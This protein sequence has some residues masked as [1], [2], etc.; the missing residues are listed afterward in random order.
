M[1]P[2][3]Q[4]DRRL[5]RPADLDPSAIALVTGA[6]SGLGEAFAW[7]LAALGWSL[8]L[9]ARRQDRLEALAK[10][11]RSAHG[12]SVTV[13]SL[14]LAQPDAVGH[15]TDTIRQQGLKVA[16][17]INNAG[18]GLPG[19]LNRLAPGAA[20]AQIQVMLTAPV[21]L[22]RAALQDMQALNFG[23][24][25]NVGSVAGFLPASPGNTLYAPIKSFLV[26]L[27]R[28]I[29]LENTQDNILISILCPGFTY[30]EFHDHTDEK[31]FSRLFPKAFWMSATR[32]VEISLQKNSRNCF[33]IIPGLINKSITQILK[34]NP[35]P[36]FNLLYKLSHTLN[37]K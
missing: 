32:V 19:D 8:V 1:R 34:F 11:L 10:A 13:V 17:L 18:Y 7:A 33:M 26:G 30:T 29:R 23:R 15:L 16:V 22:C 2:E 35:I 21:H 36:M 14:D 4:P 5:L 12:V 24:L 6:S 25:I 3:S 27:T 28:G 20:E 37:N 9:T 31:D